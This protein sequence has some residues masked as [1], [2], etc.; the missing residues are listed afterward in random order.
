MKFKIKWLLIV[1]GLLL[2]VAPVS[3]SVVDDL[4]SPFDG[5]D[6]SRP[7]DQYSSIID[8]IIYAIMFVGL[9]QA[10]LGKRFEGRDKCRTRRN[11]LGYRRSRIPALR[12]S[13]WRTS[14]DND[15]SGFGCG[16]YPKRSK[17][18]RCKCSCFYSMCGVKNGRAALLQ[19]DMLYPQ[20]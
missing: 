1:L 17:I 6:F 19:Q 9:S 13:V 5:V 10:T 8:L 16:I 14:R 2:L 12:V 20:P 15:P 7:Y 4:F 3:A 11:H 18:V